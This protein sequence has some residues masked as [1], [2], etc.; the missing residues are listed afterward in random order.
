MFLTIDEDTSHRLLNTH[1]HTKTPLYI[2]GD[3]C[4]KPSRSNDTDNL[5][6]GND[7]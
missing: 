4:R 6:V 3:V 1:T 7:V 2:H 5:F